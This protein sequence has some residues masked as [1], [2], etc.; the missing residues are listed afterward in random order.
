MQEELCEVCGETVP[1]DAMRTK[2]RL[3]CCLQCAQ[4]PVVVD[5]PAA[6]HRPEAVSSQKN[7]RRFGVAGDGIDEYYPFE[8]LTLRMRVATIGIH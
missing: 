7:Y 4:P 6:A 8:G 2:G 5:E 3:R 1:R